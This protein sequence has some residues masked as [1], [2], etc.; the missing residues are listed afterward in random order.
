MT[1]IPATNMTAFSLNLPAGKAQASSAKNMEQSFA[2]IMNGSGSQTEA[3]ADGGKIKA[4]PNASESGKQPFEKNGSS[5]PERISDEKA[6]TGKSS[7]KL[8]LEESGQIEKT[9]EDLKEEIADAMDITVEELETA[10]EALGLSLGDLLNPINLAKLTAEIVEEMDG[11]TLVTDE[12][13]FEGLKELSGQVTATV[14]ELASELGMKPEEI[15]SMLEE[16]AK[17]P[18]GNEQPEKALVSGEEEAL[19]QAEDLA[20]EEADK[21]AVKAFQPTENV[22]DE[23]PAAKESREYATIAKETS[24]NGTSVKETASAGQQTAQE[25][26]KDDSRQSKSRNGLGQETAASIQQPAAFAEGK[27]AV[28]VK[29]EAPLPTVDPQSILNQIGEAVR[30]TGGEDFTSMEMQLHPES[31]GTLH[32]QVR[33][34]EGII[35]AQFTTES[36]AVKQVLEA[37]VIQLREKLENQ[38]VKVEAVEV[39]VA[40]HEF[41]RNLEKGGSQE[42]NAYEAKKVTR[43]KIN[44]NVP[45]GEETELTEE[46]QDAVEIQKD[47]MERNGNTLDYMV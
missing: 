14:E 17:A 11:L 5:R 27:A 3:A 15:V 24:A 20:G 21:E 36:E 2:D 46:E 43:R 9:A 33:A 29:M 34:K 45:E 7:E 23:V 26:L 16:A 6:E 10:M 4:S 12:A 8:S 47:M 35:T 31:L 38:G 19:M 22:Q 37:Q 42:K 25:G 28:P 18:E 1:G 40:S 13:V 32:L 41:E 30:V 44:L 39:L